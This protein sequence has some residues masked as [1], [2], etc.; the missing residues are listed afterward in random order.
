MKARQWLAAVLS[1]LLLTTAAACKGGPV[2]PSSEQRP[3][4]D[5][6]T[7]TTTSATETSGGETGETEPSSEETSPT[8][9][10]TNPSRDPV[11]KP[12]TTTATT[13]TTTTIKKPV[14]YMFQFSDEARVYLSNSKSTFVRQNDAF[15]VYSKKNLDASTG[16]VV[17]FDANVTEHEIEGFGGAMTDTSA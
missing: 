11:K 14:K 9:S 5:A 10:E 6:A 17:E 12:T 1:V 16:L 4:S 2:S 15:K 13:T 7:S 8:E 3:S